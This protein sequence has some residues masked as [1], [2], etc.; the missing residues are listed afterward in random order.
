MRSAQNPSRCW[1]RPAGRQRSCRFFPS[2]APVRRRAF[3]KPNGR[4]AAAWMETRLGDDFD[5]GV[6]EIAGA[7]FGAN[8]LGPAGGGFD[9]APQAQY[10]H[11]DAAVEHVLIVA[12]AQVQQLLTAE[13]ALGRAEKSGKQSKLRV[14]QLDAIAVVRS[15]PARAQ[16]EFPS[17][18][19]ESLGS[20]ALDMNDGMR[21]RAAQDGADAREQFAQV[22]RFGQIIVRAEF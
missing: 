11:V 10:L 18:E 1:C 22:E 2:S 13:D 21:L 7:A 6:E 12:A 5:L 17:A 19:T 8:Q 14:G 3:F 20:A 4:Y 9:L 16:V 15:K